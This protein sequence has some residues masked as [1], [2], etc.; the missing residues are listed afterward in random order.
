MTATSMNLAASTGSQG[1]V[2]TGLGGGSAAPTGSGGSKGKPNS[3]NLALDLGN[4]YGITMLVGGFFAGFVL[5][6]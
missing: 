3:G 6:L 4:T 2:Y 5:V 1:V